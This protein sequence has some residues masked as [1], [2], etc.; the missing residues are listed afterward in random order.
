M[1]ST[2]SGVT[3]SRSTRPETDAG[4]QLRGAAGQRHLGAGAGAEN[5]GEPGV[6]EHAEG[7]G[8]HLAA[9]VLGQVALAAEQAG[10]GVAPVRRRDV[11]QPLAA[12]GGPGRRGG[13]GRA[14]RVA[15]SGGGRRGRDARRRQSATG[16]RSGRDGSAPARPSPGGDGGDG[17]GR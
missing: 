7:G 17:G 13:T 2:R 3:T 8:D 14:R 6:V 4:G 16:R 9:L 1:T 10:G 5:L 12:A 15:A 11:G